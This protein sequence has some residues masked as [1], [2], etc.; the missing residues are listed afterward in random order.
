[1]NT[2]GLSSAAVEVLGQLFTNGPTWDGNIVSKSGR[3][4]IVSVG[5]AKHLN[6]WSYLTDEGVDVAVQW[7]AS[8]DADRRWHR[9]NRQHL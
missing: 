4:E 9:K 2:L 6:G 3:S 7:D 1:M 5:L 8:G